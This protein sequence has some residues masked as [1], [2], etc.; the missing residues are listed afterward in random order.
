MRVR[1]GTLLPSALQSSCHFQITCQLLE[2]MPSGHIKVKKG[3][4]HVLNMAT[5]CHTT[6]S[7]SIIA[8]IWAM[9]NE[10]L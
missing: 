7:A 2:N 9:V 1:L 5:P 4:G 3:T 8:S 6:E 10:R